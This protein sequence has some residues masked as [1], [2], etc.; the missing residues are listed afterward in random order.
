MLGRAV[1]VVVVA[2]AA[3]AEHQPLG[4]RFRSEVLILTRII[5]YGT[6]KGVFTLKCVSKEGYISHKKF[7][8]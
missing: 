6:C 5:F 8:L 2:A 7:L 3:A 1:L 4:E